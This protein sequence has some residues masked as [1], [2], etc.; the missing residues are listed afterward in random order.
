MRRRSGVDGSFETDQVA[1]T[2]SFV[3]WE[4]SS[5]EKFGRIRYVIRKVT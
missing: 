4:E 1:G 3:P 2:P 5:Y